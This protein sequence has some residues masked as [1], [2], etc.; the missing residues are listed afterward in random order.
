MTIEDA[1][2]HRRW[3]RLHDYGV[4]N[5][6]TAAETGV[7]HDCPSSCGLRLAR[8]RAVVS[9]FMQLLVLA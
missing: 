6:S 2:K 1:G 3:C 8:W 5:S 7:L 4:S 9:A